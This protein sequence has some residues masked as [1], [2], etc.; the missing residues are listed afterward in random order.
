MSFIQ[1]NTYFTLTKYMSN[2]TSTRTVTF[3]HSGFRLMRK[4]CFTERSLQFSDFALKSLGSLTSLSSLSFL[5]PFPSVFFFSSSTVGVSLFL[6]LTFNLISSRVFLRRRV[7]AQGASKRRRPG[8]LLPRAVAQRSSGRGGS[9]AARRGRQASAAA[10]AGRGSRW[11][12]G[13]GARRRRAAPSET[14]RP[15]RAG[16]WRHGRCV[17]QAHG[18]SEQERAYAGA[19]LG[20]GALGERRLGA[21]RARVWS[22]TG[23][24]RR[25]RVVCGAARSWHARALCQVAARAAGEQRRLGS[26]QTRDNTGMDAEADVGATWRRVR[27]RTARSALEYKRWSAGAGLGQASGAASGVGATARRAWRH[28]S[29]RRWGRGGA[30]MEP[31]RGRSR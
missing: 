4:L 5:P 31:K 25:W 23:G 26:A 6:S 8:A 29:A 9:T 24:G 13:R 18:G 19:R 11:R 30:R 27:E 21:G 20:A 10:G 1:T 7:R 3:L 12:A 22:G 14:R 17:A 15:R 2:I 28:G 16:E